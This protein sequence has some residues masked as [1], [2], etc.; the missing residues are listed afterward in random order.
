MVQ[1]AVRADGLHEGRVE[2]VGRQRALVVGRR[3]DGGQ[4]LDPARTT[5][6]LLLVFRFLQTLDPECPGAG[7]RA[8]TSGP[9]SSQHSAG[10]LVLQ[11][12]TLLV[13][14]GAAGSAGTCESGMQGDTGA[15]PGS[16]EDTRA[17]ALQPRAPARTACRPAVQCTAGL[18]LSLDSG[19]HLGFRYEQEGLRRARTG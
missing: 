1:R 17:G 9:P 8:A 12:E 16:T 19:F 4:V 6:A 15:S 14:T 7:A 11:A 5:G 2:G 18:G 13:R 10:H 3:N